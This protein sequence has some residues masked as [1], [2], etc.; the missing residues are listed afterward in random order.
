[1]S[2]A[3]ICNGLSSKTNRAAP[4]IVGAAPSLF[5]IVFGRHGPFVARLSYVDDRLDEVAG[6]LVHV[7]WRSSR[8]SPHS[9]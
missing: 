9:E 6:L 5:Q 3:G 2:L 1:M 8:L 7:R 4:I